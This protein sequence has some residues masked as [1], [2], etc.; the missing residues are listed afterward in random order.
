LLAD[1]FNALKDMQGKTDVRENPKA[2]RRL[3]KEVVKIKDILS[4]NKKMLVKVG[5]LQDYITLQT[6]IERKEFEDAAEP[7]F[8]RVYKPV[9]DVLEKAGITIDEVDLIEMIGGGIRVP[10]I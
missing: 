1:R 4:A 7:F 3:L 10:K 9:E 5:E 8:A 2:M 6:T